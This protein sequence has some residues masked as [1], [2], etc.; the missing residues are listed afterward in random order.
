L[1]KFPKT[2]SGEKTASSTNVAGESSYLP[3][4]NWN[5]IHAYHFVLVSNQSGFKDLNIRPKTLHLVQERAR[6]TLEAIGVSKDFLSRTLAAQQLREDVQMGL[7]EF[8]KF[9]HNKRNGL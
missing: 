4:E 7:H 3:A 5:W 6:N 2:Y 1:T 8:K 9:W